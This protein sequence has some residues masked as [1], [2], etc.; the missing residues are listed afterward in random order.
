[1]DSVIAMEE[2]VSPEDLQVIACCYAMI[3]DW[4]SYVK[5]YVKHCV[6]VKHYPLMLFYMVLLGLFLNW[7][8][9]LNFFQDRHV[10]WTHSSLVVFWWFWC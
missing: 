8:R 7:N 10:V 2:D 5:H 4:L 9:C 1:M 6:D 3:L